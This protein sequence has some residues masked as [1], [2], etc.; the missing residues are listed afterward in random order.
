MAVKIGHAVHDEN[1]GLNGISGD[2]VQQ[3]GKKGEEVQI[4]KWYV[5]GDGW[6]WY[7]EAKDPALRERMATMM[8]VACANPNI[9]YSRTNRQ[10]WYTTAKAN[11]FDASKADGDCDCSSLVSG[12]TNLCGA[13]VKA[14]LSTKTMLSAYKASGQFNIYTDDAHLK[15]D[16]LARRGG[17][18]L[19]VGHTLMVLQNGSGIENEISE[20]VISVST[21]KPPYVLVL[22]KSVNVRNGSGVEYEKTGVAHKGDK[23]PYVGTDKSDMQWYMIEFED[24]TAFISS[25]PK[26]TK[27]VLE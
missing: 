1:G 23:F 10:K 15:S 2:Q 27:L 16:K 24:M 4:S 11:G 7:I 19:R 21:V 22:G 20:A 25:N 12:I 5:S 13:N 18:Y 14:G 9:G 17:I 26:Y 6:G 8:E 3:A